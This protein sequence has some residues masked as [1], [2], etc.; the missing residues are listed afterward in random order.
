[1]HLKFDYDQMAFRIVKYVDG[2]PA[3]STYFTR[4]KGSNTLASIMTIATRS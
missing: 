1:M 3:N 2:Q 4:Q